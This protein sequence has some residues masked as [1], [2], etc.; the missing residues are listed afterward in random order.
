MKKILI[1]PARVL[2]VDRAPLASG[3]VLIEGDKIAAVG[4]MAECPADSDA[5][6]IIDGAG[7]WLLPGL[8]DAHSHL[9][10][11]EDSLGV[12]GAD[13]NEDTDP[14]TPQLRVIDGV[15]PMER[16]FA[17]SLAAGVTT[18]VVSPG[19]ANPV[20]GQMAVLKTIGRRI[21]D[22][23]V[24]E[25][26]AIK[27][28][29]GENPKMVHRDKEEAPVTR[30]ATAALIRETLRKAVEYDARKRRAEADPDEDEP[31]YDMK[32]EALLPLL[33]GEIAAHFHAHR[34]DDM[35]TALRICREFSLRPVLVHGTEGH[36]VADLLAEEGVPVISG[37]FLTDRSK[38]ELCALTEKNPGVLARAGIPTAITCDH[39]ETPLKYLCHAAAIAV[40]AGMDESDALRA[41]TLTPA[42]I[43]DVADRVGSITPGKD[44]DLLLLTGN[45][46]DYKTAVRAVFCNGQLAYRQ[47]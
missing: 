2:P 1:R 38:P 3:F 32:Y 28:A 13:G 11:Y 42:E 36:L 41:I 29:L 20:G 27:F 40:R 19:S 47:D 15:N 31:D 25:P 30:M 6:E 44:A 24:R 9:G 46:V 16:A 37:P 34:A 43:A 17:E 39:P 45:P 35:F 18:V 14:V 4:P 26:A 10:L 5:D 33:R 8:I 21:D 7:C 23:I 12:E 22:M